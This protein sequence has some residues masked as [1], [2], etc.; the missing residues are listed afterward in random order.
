[1]LKI[2]LAATASTMTLAMMSAGASA[3]QPRAGGIVHG[4]F[5]KPAIGGMDIR[6]I[7]KGSSD[8][9]GWTVYR[10]NVDL[11][12]SQLAIMNGNGQGVS[13]NGGDQGAIKQTIQVDPGTKY[14]IKFKARLDTHPICRDE[15]YDKL[16]DQ[17]FIVG[18]SNDMDDHDYKV[19]L[20]SLDSPELNSDKKWV[21]FAEHTFV[22]TDDFVDVYFRSRTGAE[23]WDCGPM[24]TH[25]AVVPAA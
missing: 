13:L 8:L 2:V 6:F 3:E 25:V 1:M 22:P 15:P 17:Y 16:L 10:G 21:P 18:T 23:D 9:E 7:P 12:G 5:D 11:Y 14:V 20:G 24:I 4:T 19:D